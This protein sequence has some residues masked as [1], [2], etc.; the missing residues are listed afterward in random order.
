MHNKTKKTCIISKNTRYSKVL[1]MI[2]GK[3]KSNGYYN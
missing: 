3:L 2:K 1:K